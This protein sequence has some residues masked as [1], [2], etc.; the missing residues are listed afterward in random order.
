MKT[1][2]Q[3]RSTLDLC[4]KYLRKSLLAVGGESYVKEI[5][6]DDERLEGVCEN[7][8]VWMLSDDELT[9]ENWRKACD[10][11]FCFA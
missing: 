2:R 10:I 5:M 1:K 4:R 3:H 6:D 8:S 9:F 7:I 11:Y